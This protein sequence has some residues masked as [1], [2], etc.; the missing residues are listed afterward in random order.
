MIQNKISNAN[1]LGPFS[2]H[3]GPRHQR[4]PRP[5]KHYLV[6]G[7]VTIK[8]KP[9]LLTDTYLEMTADYFDSAIQRIIA[10]AIKKANSQL[11]KHKNCVIFLKTLRP[12]CAERAV[13]SRI[14]L[15]SY[16]HVLAFGLWN[17]KIAFHCRLKDQEKVNDILGPLQFGE[18]G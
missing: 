8:S 5:G 10:K 12:D 2:I 14:S 13:D 3:I 18:G 15:K 7:M 17:N 16:S 6:A 1:N 11:P 9:T 4:A